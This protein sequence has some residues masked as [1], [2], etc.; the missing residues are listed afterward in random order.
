MTTSRAVAAAGPAGSEQPDLARAVGAERLRWEAAAE[1]VSKHPWGSVPT[2]YFVAADDGVDASACT[3]Y[4]VGSVAQIEEV[5]TLLA[6][7]NRGLA[8]A[9]VLAALESA[10][11][12]GAELVFLAADDLDWPK[13]LYGRLG[14]DRLGTVEAFTRRPSAGYGVAS[15]RRPPA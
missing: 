11:T 2:R 7:R 3:L 14:F 8:R 13:E 6:H 5:A 15:T 10:V 4:S 9:V 12:G 1:S